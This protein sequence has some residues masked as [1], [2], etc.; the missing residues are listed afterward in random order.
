VV[1]AFS[2]ACAD[3]FQQVLAPVEHEA[4]K[5]AERFREEAE[6]LRKADGQA[7]T[8]LQ[9]ATEMFLSLGDLVQGKDDATFGHV[10]GAT[11]IGVNLCLFGVPE[12]IAWAALSRATPTEVQANMYPTWGAFNWIV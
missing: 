10:S 9:M 6:N 12:D 11:L 5:L 2:S 8:A 4:I 1:I 3:L 7:P